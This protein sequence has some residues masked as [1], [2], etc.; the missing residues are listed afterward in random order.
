MFTVIHS[1]LG[2]LYMTSDDERDDDDDD[3]D[4]DNVMDRNAQKERDTV[5]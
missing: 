4:D 2:F 3:D 5:D 1:L